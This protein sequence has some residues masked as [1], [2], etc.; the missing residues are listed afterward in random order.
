M[1]IKQTR[2]S[3]AKNPTHNQ[4]N[5][6]KDNK[7]DNKGNNKN[8]NEK[9]KK[10]PSSKQTSPPSPMDQDSTVEANRK[11]KDNTEESVEEPFN[12]KQALFSIPVLGGGPS[13]APH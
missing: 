6:P 9:L 12:K 3:N 13:T 10:Q 8:N 4:N 1:S 7:T 11:R 2:G 5:N